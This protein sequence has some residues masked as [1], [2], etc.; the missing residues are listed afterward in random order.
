MNAIEKLEAVQ[1]CHE[2]MEEAKEKYIEKKSNAERTTQGTF[3]PSAR[4]APAQNAR[5]N[6]LIKM[7]LLH[8]EYLEAEKQ[9]IE[10]LTGAEAIIDELDRPEWINILQCRFIKFMTWKQIA[11]ATGY[12]ERSCYNYYK[13]AIKWIQ[14]HKGGA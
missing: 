8:D 12:S 2:R 11:A 10:A 6:A 14:K 5:E 7:V 13:N 9:Y 1:E 3:E 4:E